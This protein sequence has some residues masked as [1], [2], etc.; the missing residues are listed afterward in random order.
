M[1]L[2]LALLLAASLV[3]LAATWSA[4]RTERARAHR[5]RESAAA[6]R[7]EA[8]PVRPDAS[9]EPRPAA[10]TAGS[11]AA[12]ANV[13]S[14]EAALPAPALVRK[15]AGPARTASSFDRLAEALAAPSGRLAASIEA[16]GPVLSAAAD[17]L[18][19]PIPPSVAA[20]GVEAVA[21]PDFRVGTLEEAVT[22]AERLSDERSRLADDLRSLRA[23]LERVSALDAGLGRSLAELSRAADTLLPLASSVSGLADRAN[24]L[25]LNVSLLAARAGEA[26]APF[27][28]AATEL[29]GLFE[30]A[31]RLSRELAEIARRSEGG[32]RKVAA[33]VQESAGSTATG[34]ERGARADERLGVLRE[35]CGHLDG[36]LAESLRSVRSAAEGAEALSRSLDVAR[37]SLEAKSGESTR[38]RAEAETVRVALRSAAER[39]EALRLDGGALRAAVARVAPGA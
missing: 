15:E 4:L 16:S 11:V 27:E 14:V 13:A 26:G 30:E 8:V 6:A 36:S 28:E 2:V 25:G 35:L 31:R 32:S 22:T 38:L 10:G 7:S 24:L 5:L 34:Q 1:E 3:A 23:S 18:R 21:V 12:V 20:P 37:T 17:R 29:R 9:L 33:L 39:I 19:T